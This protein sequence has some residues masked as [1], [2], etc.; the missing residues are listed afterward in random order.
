M[1][2]PISG[3]ATPPETRNTEHGTRNTP[4]N[5]SPMTEQPA[6]T[7][8]D[9]GRQA[10]ARAYAAITRRLFFVELGLG[11]VLLA[12]LLF[13][14]GSA[15]LRDWAESLVPAG[16]WGGALVLY[17]GVLVLGYTL[18]TLPLGY[19]SGFVLPQR[20]GLSTETRRLWAMDQVKGLLLEALL[21]TP[22]ALALYG[23]L[24]AFPDT[25]WLLMAALL[26]LVGI[27]LGQLA[28]V[29]LMP[30]FNRFTP[31]EEGPLRIRL[32]EMAAAAGS[33]VRG[34]F[35]MD[36]SKRTTAANAMFTGIGPTRRIILGDT[37]L[38]GYSEDEIETVLAHELAHQ[39]HGDLWRGIALQAVLTLAGMGLAALGLQAGAGAFGFRGIADPA[40]FP[41]LVAVF[42]VFGLVL[43]PVTNAFTRRMERAADAYALRVTRKPRAFQAVMAKLAGQNLSDAAPPAWVRLLFYSHPPIAERI[44]AA[45][46]FARQQSS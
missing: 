22:L 4:P 32:L 37:L 13:S 35:V 38:Q 14:G 7:Q 30:L 28:P 41:V 29:L 33:P 24:R 19:Y 2:D 42:S 18:I 15:A 46:A 17:L 21:G 8:L 23:L 5:P 45:E 12:A 40:A 20:Y 10:T 27:L 11:A 34:V 36:L 1:I 6:A 44:A 16:L 25:W 26:I 39:V 31:L 3:P 9:P 43:L